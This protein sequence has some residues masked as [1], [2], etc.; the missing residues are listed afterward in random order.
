VDF[1][2]GKILW[3]RIELDMFKNPQSGD[4]EAYI[5]ALDIDQKKTSNALVYSVVNFGYDYL[6]L[7]DLTTK[8]YTI[9]EKTESSTPLPTFHVSN[10]ETEV[11][12][13]ARKFLV[14]EDIE[15]NIKEM[16]YEN[17]FNQLETQKIYTTYCR[18]K[19]NDGRISRKKLQFSYLD[20]KRKK[21]IATRT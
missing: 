13:Y 8:K 10:Y 19:E 18:V 5:Y 21:I 20:S 15:K 1:G 6:A 17:L 16:S 4:I 12:Q 11:A 14:E 9:F 3:I 7:L 2:E